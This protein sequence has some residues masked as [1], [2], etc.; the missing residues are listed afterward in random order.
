MGTKARP[1]SENTW[2]IQD[3]RGNV[4]FFDDVGDDQASIQAIIPTI[5]QEIS[6]QKGLE[7][8]VQ[9]RPSAHT[10]RRV[11][12]RRVSPNGSVSA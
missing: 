4:I 7:A 3:R 2:Q 9:K 12:T 1:I 11:S 5:G 8:I 6:L 10:R